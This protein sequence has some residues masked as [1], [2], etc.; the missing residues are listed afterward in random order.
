[1]MT[2]CTVNS[3]Q[4]TTAPI[5]T[6]EPIPATEPISTSEPITVSEPI[7]AQ[8]VN[9]VEN[10][11]PVTIPSSANEDNGFTAGIRELNVLK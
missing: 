10:K 1:M 8:T 5:T 9:N 7:P 11:N 3:N 2:G 6:S 4:D